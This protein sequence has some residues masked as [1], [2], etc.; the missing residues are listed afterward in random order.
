MSGR[1]TDINGVLKA[2][3]ELHAASY[4]NQR[5]VWTGSWSSS[6]TRTT[7]VRV[8]GTT[9]RPRVDLDAFVAGG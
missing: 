3:V 8:V 6:V 7:P 9:G 5:V 2:T 4:Q 1:R